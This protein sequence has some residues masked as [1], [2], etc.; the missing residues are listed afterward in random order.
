MYFRDSINKYAILRKE[1]T[2]WF[3]MLK[4]SQTIEKVLG[5]KWK[6]IGSGEKGLGEMYPNISSDRHDQQT[7]DEL[8]KTP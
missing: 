4:N 6:N 8:R 7:W 2:D 3:S 5:T 1:W